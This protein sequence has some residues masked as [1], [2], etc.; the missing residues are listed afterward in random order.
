MIKNVNNNHEIDVNFNGDIHN[1]PYLFVL[2]MY[3]GEWIK[4]D[5]SCQ[6]VLSYQNL[7]DLQENIN[8]LIQEKQTFDTEEL[9]RKE[10]SRKIKEYE[11]LKKELSNYGYLK[12]TE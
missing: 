10:M 3:N 11:K 9:E 6:A 8:D 1:N 4:S 12:K 2:T 5:Q 7:I